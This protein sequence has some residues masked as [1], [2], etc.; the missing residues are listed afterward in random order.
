MKKSKPKADSRKRKRPDGIGGNSTAQNS[1]YR[2]LRERV[3]ARK[4]AKE[5]LKIAK[6]I[7]ENP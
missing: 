7:E 6:M 2:D 5:I 1:E 4:D 3:E